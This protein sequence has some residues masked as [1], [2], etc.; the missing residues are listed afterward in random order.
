MSLPHDVWVQIAS[1]ISASQLEDLYSLNHAL[2]DIAMNHRYQ[3]ISFSYLTRKM[4]RTLERIRDPYVARRVRILYLHPHFVKDV[5]NKDQSPILPSNSTLLSR[6]G[7]FACHLRDQKLFGKQRSRSP[8]SRF[9]SYDEF[10]Q[11]M[12]DV[13]SSLPNLTDV[14]LA[15][16]GL[17]AVSDSPVPII[18]AAFVPKVRRLWLE[19]SLEKLGF[20]LP[21][22]SSLSDV[23]ELDLFIRIDHELDPKRYDSI[24]IQFAQTV[25]NLHRTLRKFAI[26]L[27]EPLDLSSFF[28]SLHRLPFLEHIS[29][30]IPLGRPHLGDTDAIADFFNL[31]STSLRSLTIRATELGEWAR[32]SDDSH[33]CDW[34]ET[35]F[36]SV[37]LLRLTSLEIS[38]GLIPVESAMVCI[39][40]FAGTLKHL[41]LTGRHLYFHDIEAIT[42]A[43]P[44]CVRP[45]KG[46]YGL[47]S[48]RLG[49][50]ILNPQLMDMLAERLPY[51]RKLDLL[52]RDVVPCEGHYPLYYK[53]SPDPDQ[54]ESQLVLR[55]DGAEVLPGLEG[56]PSHIIVYFSALQIAARTAI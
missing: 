15:W 38:L 18:C 8:L 31:H 29:L 30:S 12:V 51:V 41:V 28:S 42:S 39:R 7:D 37:R 4:I 25:N 17:P 11:V 10:Q 23:E 48:V 1:Y 14:H 16:S 53:N 50:V 27:W 13:L 9:K 47:E 20:M 56:S 34:I 36:A 49:S 35:T 55:G 19:V 46:F 26:Q 24:L 44:H 22:F 5:M 6:L 43:F 3:Q 40:K 52:V 45:S 33:L 32:A 54:D 21:H 2:F